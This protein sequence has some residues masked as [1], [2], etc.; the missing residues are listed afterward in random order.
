M[1]N[2]PAAQA[3]MANAYELVSS[4]SSLR[5]HAG[6]QGE[7]AHRAGSA[8]EAQT[9]R[10]ISSEMDELASVRRLPCEP[11][12]LS[13]AA[14]VREFEETISFRSRQ[15]K[16]DPRRKPTDVEVSFTHLGRC[17]SCD[18]YAGLWRSLHGESTV[19]VG[20][21]PQLLVDD[22]VVER[23]R[24]AVRF[25]NPPISPP[26]PILTPAATSPPD[27][28]FGC[29]CSAEVLRGGGVRLWHASGGYVDESLVREA[30]IERE[31][32]GYPV[33]RLK[34]DWPA[35]YVVRTSADGY[36]NWSAPLAVSHDM[37]AVGTF[38][39]SPPPLRAAANDDDPGAADASPRRPYYA[40]YEGY[41]GRTCVARSDDGVRW[42]SLGAAADGATPGSADHACGRGLRS[43]LGRAADTYITVVAD[44]ARRRDLVWHRR[45]FGTAG[46][47]R[48]IRGVRVAAVD[49]GLAAY[50][51]RANGSAAPEVLSWYLDRLGKLERFRR[52]VY[53]ATLTRHGPDLWLG[54]LTVIE[55]AKDLTERRA[56]DAPAVERDV[57]NIYLVTSRDGVHIDDEWVYAHRPLVPRAATQAGWSSGFVLPA[58][59]IVTTAD[60]HRVYF[61]ARRGARHEE[62]LKGEPA[63]IGV[64]TFRR[65]MLVGV[66]AAHADR[67]A[68]VQTKAFA[69]EGAHLSLTVDASKGAGA[70]VTVE[71][72]HAATRRKRADLIA[73]APSVGGDGASGEV[74]VVWEG[75]AAGASCA[76]VAAALRASVR[77]RFTLHA[78]AEL[79]GFRWR[80]TPARP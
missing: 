76:A 10:A 49:G 3:A 33:P 59:Q 52:Q 16:K 22:H 13:E 70:H 6:P 24:N 55:W 58:A 18:N 30:G 66:R 41:L 8:L 77:L 35:R 74:A 69:L 34:A 15:L 54:L 56:P 73:A 62:R 7:G 71:L 68:V 37:L 61:E 26:R 28:R 5:L 1:V 32:G 14:L 48:E 53:A 65:D 60:E 42:R 38:A 43:F 51:R 78:G 80:R 12:A 45:D 72:L 40:G 47:W 25:L 64:A 27:Q 17:T 75:C 44:D 9:R 2:G 36:T 39:V 63:T 20:T 11:A 67:P 31:E 23:W 46:G 4:A 29:P 50:E 19:D 79:Y 21:R 57:T